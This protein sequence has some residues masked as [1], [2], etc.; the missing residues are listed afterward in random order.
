MKT[1]RLIDISGQKFG[2]LTVVSFSGYRREGKNGHKT[3]EWKCKCECGNE[4]VVTK[5]RLKSGNT[6]SCGCMKTENN[7]KTWTKHGLCNTRLYK[8]FSMMKDRCYN[9]NSKAYMYYGGKGV[10][11]CDEW[12][13]DFQTFYDWA[14]QNGYDDNLTI[15]RIDVNGNYEPDNCMWITQSEQMRNRT[16]THFILFEGKKYTLTELSNKL[17]VSRTTIR[18]HEK[19][20]CGDSEKAIKF[21][22][23]NQKKKG[24]N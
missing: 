8:I 15:E 23:E 10:F 19:Y 22:I 13:R 11:I 3:S 16:N 20:F 9:K 5:S 1:S 17:G 18:K 4:V 12:L 24:R 14:I 6:K 7:I 21:I 2:R